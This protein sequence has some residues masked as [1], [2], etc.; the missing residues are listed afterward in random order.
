[1][2]NTSLL[3]F[4][5]STKEVARVTMDDVIRFFV[6]YMR[7]D[8]LGVICNSHLAIADSSELGAN[9][10]RCLQLAKLQSTAVDYPKTGHPAKM[11]RD[12]H[13]PTYPDFMEKSDKAA[14]RSEKIIGK[15]YQRIKHYQPI[16]VGHLLSDL[17][18]HFDQGLVV[19]GYERFVPNALEVK[20]A[21]DQE[22]KSIMNR[23]HVRSEAEAIGG[24]MIN[25]PPMQRRH[26]LHDMQAKVCNGGG[27]G[28]APIAIKVDA[29]PW[30]H[31]S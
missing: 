6:D 10:P 4:D 27:G 16:D 25:L 1:M 28:G 22:L 21:Y 8:I 24:F 12:H 14:H 19:S 18:S 20:A 31:C 2:Y 3:V 11:N 15:L 30:N 26:S 9:D 7:N 29:W 23:Y 17:S 5:F 13:P